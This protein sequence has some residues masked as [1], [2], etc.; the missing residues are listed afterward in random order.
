M[1]LGVLNGL[2]KKEKTIIISRSGFIP[3]SV[4]CSEHLAFGV[5]APTALF[6]TAL[7]PLLLYSD[8]VSG[9]FSAESTSRPA[10]H[11][12][13]HLSSTPVTEESQ[14]WY[15][16]IRVRGREVQSIE[17]WVV[18][19]AVAHVVVCIVYDKLNHICIP[20]NRRVRIQ[21]FLVLVGEHYV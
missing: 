4:L 14:W 9:W 3:L 2:L 5:K 16:R 21:L 19:R 1:L 15:W 12:K 18:F 8:A 17:W 20:D 7:D 13:K 10:T 6:L 11:W